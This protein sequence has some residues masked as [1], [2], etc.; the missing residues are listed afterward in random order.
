MS[1][2]APHFFWLLYTTWQHSSWKYFG[3]TKNPI[4]DHNPRTSIE[5]YISLL[6]FCNTLHWKKMWLDLLKRTEQST[7][8]LLERY[9]VRMYEL[10]Y[11]NCYHNVQ[12][13]VLSTLQRRKLFIASNWIYVPRRMLTALSPAQC[14]KAVYALSGT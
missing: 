14:F 12:L 9:C 6:R 3:V 7:F 2:T 1:Q 4:E 11:E 5:F 13:W 10:I 8:Q